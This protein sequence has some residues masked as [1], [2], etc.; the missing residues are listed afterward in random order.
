[1]CEL[2][3]PVA[4]PAPR[5][6]R[7]RRSAAAGG[8]RRRLLRAAGAR[9]QVRRSADAAARRLRRLD[10]P[11]RA[12]R[13]GR[14]LLGPARRPARAR[15]RAAAS[16]SRRPSTRSTTSAR[17]RELAALGVDGIFTDRPDLLRA[18][19]S[20]AEDA[21][22]R[23]REA[24]PRRVVPTGKRARAREADTSAVS[25]SPPAVDLQP[26][27]RAEERVRDAPRRSAPAPS[28]SHGLELDRLGPHEHQHALAA[29]RGRGR[30]RRRAACR[31]SRRCRCASAT[32]A[33]SRFIVPT[34]SATNGVAG[35]P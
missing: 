29:S 30:R 23:R 14:R 20:S 1:M 24:R 10:P 5:R 19:L 33:S 6:R 22:A 2:K 9:S 4:L 25:S 17:M 13:V 21:G 18:A 7:A 34:N 8:R 15:A 32:V 16:A 26:R 31:R 35:A 27:R 12:L 3:T 11:R 28:P